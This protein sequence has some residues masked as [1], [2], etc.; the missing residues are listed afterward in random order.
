MKDFLLDPISNLSP[1]KKL[2][3]DIKNK[4][5]PI[6]LHG[7]LEENMGHFIMSLNKKVDKQILLITYN[8]KKSKEIYEDLKN[9]YDDVDVC[10]FP[11]KS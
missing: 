11:K 4:V 1:Y 6:A 10:L 7:I 3:D 8:E 9:I 5:S 2:I